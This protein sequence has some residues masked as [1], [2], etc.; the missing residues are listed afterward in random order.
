MKPNETKLTQS[1]KNLPDKADFL[2]NADPTIVLFTREVNKSE[3]KSKWE[4]GPWKEFARTEIIEDTSTPSFYTWFVLPYY[5]DRPQPLLFKLYDWE[6]ISSENV[7]LDMQTLLGE[8]YTSVTTLVRTSGMR[9]RGVVRAPGDG[10]D[11]D[12]MAMKMAGSDSEEETGPKHSADEPSVG[13]TTKKGIRRGQIGEEIKLLKG[14]ITDVKSLPHLTIASYWTYDNPVVPE[15]WVRIAMSATEVRIAASAKVS[16]PDAFIEVYRDSDGAFDLVYRSEVQYDTHRPKWK[17]FAIP[18][19]RLCMCFQMN[20]RVVIRVFDHRPRGFHKLIGTCVRTAEELMQAAK[21]G[22]KL[23][24]AK[25]RHL[26]AELN[27]L[28]G[29]KS[30]QTGPDGGAPRGPNL[31][32]NMFKVYGMKGAVLPRHNLVG[33]HDATSSATPAPA[34][35]AAAGGGDAADA[36]PAA[37]LTKQKS[38]SRADRQMAMKSS[39]AVPRPK[40][41]GKSEKHLHM[42]QA[43]VVPRKSSSPF[44]E[45]MPLSQ[46]VRFLWSVASDRVSR[47]SP[48]LGARVRDC[49]WTLHETAQHSGAAKEHAEEERRRSRSPPSRRFRSR[50]SS[51]AGATP[52]TDFLRHRPHSAMDFRTPAAEASAPNLG[53][54]SAEWGT[55]AGSSTM[56]A[57]PATLARGRTSRMDL[58]PR[59]GTSAG[60]TPGTSGRKRYADIAAQ[61]H[62]TVGQS[63][64]GSQSAVDV[65]M[66]TT[67]SKTPAQ[68]RRS[69]ARARTSP[70]TGYSLARMPTAFTPVPPRLMEKDRRGLPT[71]KEYLRQ[72]LDANNPVWKRVENINLR[73]VTGID[74]LAMYRIIAAKGGTI[75]NAKVPAPASPPSSPPPITKL[76]RSKPT[77]MSSGPS[78]KDLAKTMRSMRRASGSSASRTP[79]STALPSSLSSSAVGL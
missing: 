72:L 60:F 57:V 2:T 11:P 64:D 50:P 77:P 66:P 76:L 1:A 35:E 62:K 61:R 13:L 71:H 28:D 4:Y 40:D 15:Q 22:T 34:A 42:R 49:L 45:D 58:P 9:V 38:V 8:Y 55:P 41:L 69:S 21:D 74:K 17:P 14:P 53:A 5:R 46:D 18:L 54:A 43:I 6:S 33:R 32:I 26:E 67:A 3:D 31:T 10:D 65:G 39:I 70:G 7:S 36:P 29:K 16:Q 75:Q 25:D 24:C 73:R 47:T 79:S 23:D 44:P 56:V 48:E 52:V 51:R 20:R 59:P 78:H 37:Q 63:F 19:S 30:P 27:M 12:E 68:K